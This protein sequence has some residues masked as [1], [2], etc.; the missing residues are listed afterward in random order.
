MAEAEAAVTDQW[1]AA[2]APSTQFDCANAVWVAPLT[3]EYMLDA[4]I[5]LYS[6]LVA[7]CLHLVGPS[8]PLTRDS[9]RQP[10]FRGRS[11]RTPICRRYPATWLSKYLIS[12]T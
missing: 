9:P 11:G 2:R 6:I 12:T 5:D 7:C 3:L 10:I 4:A 1:Q 8:R